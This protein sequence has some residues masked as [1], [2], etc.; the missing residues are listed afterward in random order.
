MKCNLP[1][2]KA[3]FGVIST[4][5]VE[6]RGLCA[7]GPLDTPKSYQVIPATFNVFQIEQKFLEPEAH[8]T[9]HGGWLSGLQVGPTQTDKVTMGASL[10]G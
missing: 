10:R 2:I 7:D 1:L 3:Y 6:K 8:A 4:E 9:P 5:E